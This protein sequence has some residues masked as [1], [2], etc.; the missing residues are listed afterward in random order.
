MRTGSY[1]RWIGRKGT[2]LQRETL[3]A[4]R[5]KTAAQQ[6]RYS[7]RVSMNTLPFSFIYKK[8]TL[9]KA[10]GLSLFQKGIVRSV[11][12]IHVYQ[13]PKAEIS[14]KYADF[15]VLTQKWYT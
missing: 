3:A 4:D 1:H 8:G 10:I 2:V 15:S 9:N 14:G 6:R 13:S 11:F 5:T 7:V 12:S